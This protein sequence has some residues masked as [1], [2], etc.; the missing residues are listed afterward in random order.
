MTVSE[1]NFIC[2]SSIF[3][4]ISAKQR[5]RRIFQHSTAQRGLFSQSSGHWFISGLQQNLCNI[6]HRLLVCVR[7]NRL[8]AYIIPVVI[9]NFPTTNTVKHHITRFKKRDFRRNRQRSVFKKLVKVFCPVNN[10]YIHS[11]GLIYCQLI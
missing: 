5:Q 8:Q 4:S 7:V 10:A 2:D 11:L 9:P 3:L 1:L 6:K